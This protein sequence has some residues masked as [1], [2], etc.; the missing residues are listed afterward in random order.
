M[1]NGAHAEMHTKK[2]KREVKRVASDESHRRETGGGGGLERVAPFRK[3]W[4]ALEK[5]VVWTIYHNFGRAREKRVFFKDQGTRDDV[6]RGLKT[7]GFF[8]GA[9]K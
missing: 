8:T 5:E 7:G 4:C 1:D 2:R 3:K 6:K 9:E